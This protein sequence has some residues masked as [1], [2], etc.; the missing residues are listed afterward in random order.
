[1]SHALVERLALKLQQ[2]RTSL[3]IGHSHSSESPNNRTPRVL[4]L[5]DEALRNLKIDYADYKQF[6]VL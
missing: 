6:S 4:L 5:G 1:M 2:S 3:L